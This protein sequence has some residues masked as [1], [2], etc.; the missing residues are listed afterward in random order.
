[1]VLDVDSTLCGIEGIDWLAAHR[2]E[3]LRSAGV[4]VVLVSGGLRASIVPLALSLGFEEADVCAVEVR[5]DHRGAYDGFD[6]DSPLA[7][8]NG[9]PRV[10][11][12]LGLA[13]PILAVGDGVTDLRIR[14]DGACDA[15]A[16]YTGFVS[17]EPVV[18][19]ADHE[20]ASF[21]ALL[22]LVFSEQA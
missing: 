2:G 21:E 14:A 7:T 19:V 11:A 10:V 17:R 6:R 3:K 9:K 1:M 4:R 16:A 5:H 12:S 22:S 15:F 8:S 18:D 20:I 13:H